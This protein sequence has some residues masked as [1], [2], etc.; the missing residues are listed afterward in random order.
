MNKK[1][2]F[3]FTLI[4]ILLSYTFNVDRIISNKLSA[5]NTSIK[6]SIITNI[7]SL[8]NTATTHF[9]QK[10]QINTLSQLVLENERYKL[11]Y[12]TSHNSNNLLNI[13]KVI[14]YNNF[15]NFSEVILSKN[16][17]TKKISALITKDGFSA[18]IALCKDNKTIGYLNHHP[19]SNYAVFVGNEKVPGITHGE[20]HN[21]YIKIKFIPKW[22][23]IN[24]GDKVITSG[25]DNI[26]P[27][28]IKVGYVT[29]IKSLSN[30]LVAYVKPYTD[31]Y[32]EKYFYLYS[33]DTNNT[34]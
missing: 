4:L 2:L 12:L 31:A 6:Q 28:G 30:T 18:G 19:K 27:F 29:K 16:N 11:L 7:N 9:D 33:Q 15:N 14:S 8:I 34:N 3:S 22:K 20:K 23:N 21:E 24:I 5:L 26:F 17:N 25:M 32:D 13:S 1:F 10:A